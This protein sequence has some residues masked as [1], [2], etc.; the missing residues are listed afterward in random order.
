[1]RI[2]NTIKL[3]AQGKEVE[4]HEIEIGGRIISRS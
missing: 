1:L 3:K 4:F 2:T